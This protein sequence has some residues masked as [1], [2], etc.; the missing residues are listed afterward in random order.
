MTVLERAWAFLT[1]PA[2]RAVLGWLGG[3]LVVA[4]GGV[5]TVLTYFRPSSTANKAGS[6]PA[7]VTAAHGSVAIGRDNRD[8]PITI[9]GS[10]QPSGP[11][12]QQRKAG[13]GKPRRRGKGGKR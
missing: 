11:P 6:E 12:P 10:P 8:G 7:K 1:D 9:S 4:L 5:W 13:A 2:N 3:G